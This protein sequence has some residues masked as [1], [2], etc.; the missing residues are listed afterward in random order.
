MFKTWNTS[1]LFQNLQCTVQWRTEHQMS[2]R[3]SFSRCARQIISLKWFWFIMFSSALLG[4]TVILPWPRIFPLYSMKREKLAVFIFPC[5]HPIPQNACQHSFIPAHT[6]E[7]L[8]RHLFPG[9]FDK[10]H[11]RGQLQALSPVLSIYWKNSWCFI[12]LS[13]PLPPFSTFS[14][15]LHSSTVFAL[16]NNALQCTGRCFGCSR[17]DCYTDKQW[18]SM[19]FLLFDMSSTLLRQ[20]C[21]TPT[22]KPTNVKWS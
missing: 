13:S 22:R 10:L 18:A 15:C 11:H 6:R 9:C 14:S 2:R 16:F 19:C 1:Q 5:Y 20:A 4:F 17:L 7:I 3:I 21:N 12:W 8:Q